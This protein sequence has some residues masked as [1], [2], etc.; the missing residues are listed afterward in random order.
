MQELRLVAVSEDGS[1]RSSR[2]RAQRAFFAANRRPAED[3]ARGVLPA[4]AVEIEV[5]S[6]LRPKE[7]QDRIRAG[8]TAE[9]IADAAG[10]PRTMRRFRG[11]YRGRSLGRR[12]R[13]GTVG[14]G[15]AGAGPRLGEVVTER[16]L[17]RWPEDQW[18]SRKREDGNWQVQ[19]VYTV[20]GRMQMA[21][22]VIRPRAS[23]CPRR[24]TTA[25][26]VAAGS[27]RGALGP[28]PMTPVR[29]P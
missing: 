1:T 22:W 23:M 8:E 20:G 16:W 2:S 12:K 3:V 25:A 18:D 26:P 7:I 11:R 19:L 4:G 24:T 29:L 10:V 5:E 14:P 15:D 28:S 6:P 17:S 9:E 21:E 27:Q 13:S